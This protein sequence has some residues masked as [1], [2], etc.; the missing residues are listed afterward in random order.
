MGI[1]GHCIQIMCIYTDIQIDTLV[2]VSVVPTHPRTQ[3]TEY[4]VT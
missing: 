2:A 4:T 1:H 3:E